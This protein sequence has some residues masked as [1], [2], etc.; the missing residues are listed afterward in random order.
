MKKK[1][2][3]ALSVANTTA[4]N[5]SPRLSGE[6]VDAES[7]IRIPRSRWIQPHALVSMSNV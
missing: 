2:A 3:M 5:R 7:R 6:E 1:F 4:V